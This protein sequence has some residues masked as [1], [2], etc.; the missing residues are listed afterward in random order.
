MKRNTAKAAAITRAAKP[1]RDAFEAKFPFCWC[2]GTS[3]NLSIDEAARGI[4]RLN[5]LDKEYAL[6]RACWECNSGPLT[7][8]GVYPL[9]RKLALVWLFNR[10]AFRL[11]GFNKLRGRALN[12]I[13]FYE[14]EVWIT[15]ELAHRGWDSFEPRR[16]A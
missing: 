7:D 8:A 11:K 2:C 3:C 5:A 10:S 1:V 15:R 14:V 13:E 9:E 12:A 6:L 4:H 16:A